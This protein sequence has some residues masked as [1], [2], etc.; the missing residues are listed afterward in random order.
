MGAG[1]EPGRQLHCERLRPCYYCRGSEATTRLPWPVTLPLVF[2]P[3]LFPNSTL[4]YRND[5]VETSFKY[6]LVGNSSPG[7]RVVSQLLLS[8]ARH[9]TTCQCSPSS[10]FKHRVRCSSRCGRPCFFTREGLWD[11]LSQIIPS[12]RRR[13]PVFHGGTNV[14]TPLPGLF[15]CRDAV[16]T[17]HSKTLRLQTIQV[18]VLPGVLHFVSLPIYGQFSFCYWDVAFL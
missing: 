3:S 2:I 13:C 6:L 7:L 8:P 17:L 4:V 5:L 18:D 14:S 12:A 9:A 16:R 1:R 10:F 15:L 11:W